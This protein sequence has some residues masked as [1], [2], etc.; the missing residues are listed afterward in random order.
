M[1]DQPD[2]QAAAARLMKNQEDIGKAVAAYYGAAAGQQLTTLLKEHISIAVDLVKAAKAG[3]KNTQQQADTRWQQ[4]A[5]QIADFLSKANPHWPRATLVDMMKMHLSTT[6]SEVVARLNKNW[7][8]DV[9]AFDE[10]YTHILKMSDALAD[11]IVRQFPEKFAGARRRAGGILGRM[12]DATNGGRARAYQ[13]LR[14]SEELHRA[15][16][17]SISDA[18]FLT[19]DDGD[20]RFVCPNVDVIFG[21]GPDEVHAMRNIDRLLGD[22]IVD[23]PALEERGE[24]RNVERRVTSKSG[25]RRTVLVHVKRVAIQGGTM[26]YTCRDVTEHRLAEEALRDA[27]ME[28]AHASR[29]ALVGELVGAM[30]HEITQPLTSI[31]LNAR[32]GVRLSEAA[33]SVDALSTFMDIQ[34]DGERAT[35]IIEHLRALMRKKP[36]ELRP[37]DMNAIVRD[38]IRLVEVDA[39]RRGVRIDIELGAS[40]PPVIADRISMQQVILNLL[41]NAMDAMDGVAAD[42]RQL[43]VRTREVTGAVEVAVIDRGPGFAPE[44]LNKL[45]SAFYTTKPEGLGLGL[46]IARSIIEAHAGDIRV[47]GRGSPGATFRFTIPADTRGRRRPARK[48]R[49]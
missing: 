33:G 5:V 1:A 30:A 37:E 44:Q 9:R 21:Y 35:A 47:E 49:H 29:L 40:L 20:F 25:D 31:V 23:R 16:L 41:V 3:D 39:L 38:T 45:F 32:S 14:E 19:G 2:A 8:Q 15:T 13:A 17:S 27:R 42:Q 34:H 12:D 48:A 26:L 28:L 36:M 18:V 22:R 24:V 46:R 6:T 43:I 4:N 11:G 10:V 7:D